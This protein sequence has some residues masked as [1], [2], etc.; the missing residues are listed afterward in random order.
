MRVRASV[1][2]RAAVAALVVGLGI[3]TSLYAAATL[4]VVPAQIRA[5][6]VIVVLGGDGPPRAAEA[7]VLFR[8]GL[9]P[10]VLVS[11]DG[12]CQSIRDLMIAQ[13]V[14]PSAIFLECVSLSTY[15]NAMFSS[16]LLAGLRVRS[17]LLVTSW[18][19]L[20]RALACMS[21]AAPWIR[22]RPIPA[23]PPP[24]GSRW[25]F[26]ILGYAV[27]VAEEYA[28]LAWYALHYGIA[29]ARSPHSRARSDRP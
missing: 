19:H 15:E 24:G 4:L 7:A 9:A 22:W 27:P 12:D 8:A 20:R 16:P 28:K 21:L 3:A 23:P 26:G 6:D 25:H 17:A 1:L 14:A 10:R 29:P 18:F 2:G 11:G 5:S 13:G